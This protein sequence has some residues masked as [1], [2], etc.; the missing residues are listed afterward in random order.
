L[1]PG[2]GGGGGETVEEV[3]AGGHFGLRSAD[4]G[5]RNGVVKKR[6][7]MGGAFWLGWN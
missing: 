2:G 1:G 4:L 6:V 5:L 7:E 3:A